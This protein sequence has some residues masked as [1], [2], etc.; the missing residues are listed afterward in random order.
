M[1]LL[2][3]VAPVMPT[4]QIGI[5]V[6]GIASDGWIEQGASCTSLVIETGRDWTSMVNTINKLMSVLPEL[7]GVMVG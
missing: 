6:G 2:L 7:D 4:L 3:H 5:S 1:C